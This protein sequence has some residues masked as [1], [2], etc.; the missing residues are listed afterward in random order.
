[1][2][3]KEKITP[4]EKLLKIIENPASVQKKV[5]PGI[6][7]TVSSFLG[8]VKGL[9]STTGG[10][11][12]IDMRTANRLLVALCGLVTIYAAA[13]LIREGVGLNQR[14]N[15]IASGAN[16]PAQKEKEASKLTVPKPEETPAEAQKRNIFTLT[17]KEKPIE[18]A[19]LSGGAVELKL[20]GIL[21]SDNPQAMIEDTKAQK[22]YLVSQ[23]DKI[24]NVG[25]KAILINKVVL[26]K[27]EQEWDLR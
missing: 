3:D 4:E 15:K 19:D 5:L 20:V 1:M 7:K 14:F 2:A 27:D 9:A 25:V 17:Q 6:N 24:G 21:W 22:T 26:T 12:R 18:R 16:I 13:Y 10:P 11:W 8:W 23:G